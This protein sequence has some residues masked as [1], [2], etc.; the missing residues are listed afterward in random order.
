MEGKHPKKS[1]SSLAVFGVIAACHNHL[2]LQYLDERRV[3]DAITAFDAAI[4]L[5]RE[6]RRLFPNDRENEVYL[7]GAFC[8]RGY[9][10]TDIDPETAAEF[11]KESLSVLRQPIQ[12]CDCS[13]WDESRQTWWCEQLEV[14]GDALKLPW[15]TLA[16]QFIDNAMMGLRSLETKSNSDE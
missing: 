11:Y 10:N 13:Y 8:N 2:G 5:R 15:V 12:T 1:T 3:Q 7:G 16:P 9:A 4:T 14:M 6:L